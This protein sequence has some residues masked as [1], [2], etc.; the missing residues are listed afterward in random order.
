MIMT[1]PRP[2]PW[3]LKTRESSAAV[4]AVAPTP[5]SATTSKRI[6]PV[7]TCPRVS[8]WTT[9]RSYGPRKRGL[10]SS[11]FPSA[12]IRGKLEK[13]IESYAR[14]Q[15]ARRVTADLM[16]EGMQGEE[17]PAMAGIPSWAKGIER[18]GKSG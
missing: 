2:W 14:A 10:A 1:A 15:G 8:R 12:F 16:Q 7:P 11:A 6:P 17:R 9:E 18:P 3:L 4:A 13:G 5:G